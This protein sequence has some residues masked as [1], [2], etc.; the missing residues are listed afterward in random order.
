MTTDSWTWVTKALVVAFVISFLAFLGLTFHYVDTAT[1]IQYP[2]KGKVYELNVH[3]WVVYLDYG[4]H[5]MLI[6]CEAFSALCAGQ[7]W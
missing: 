1:H 4:Q 6:A 2:G 5:V 3:G 7:L